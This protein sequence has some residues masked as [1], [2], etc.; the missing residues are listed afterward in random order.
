VSA[1]KSSAF[2]KKSAQKTFG[3]LVPGSGNA[4]GPDSKKFFA[5]FFQKSSASF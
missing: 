5:T 4:P 3:I 2:L 1:G